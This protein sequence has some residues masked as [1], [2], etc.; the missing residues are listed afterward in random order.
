VRSS[1]AGALVLTMLSSLAAAPLGAEEPHPDITLFF[2]AASSDEELAKAALDEISGNWRDGYTAMFIDFARMMRP[3]SRARNATNEG[4]RWLGGESL[5]ADS[6]DNSGTGETP[7]GLSRNENAGASDPGSPIRRRLLQFLKK[8]TGRKYGDDLDGWRRWMWSLPYDPHPEYA[9]LKA[10]I[11]RNIDP[12]MTEFL[13]PDRPAAIRLDEIDWGGVRVNGVPPLD[14][15]STI[16]ADAADY[17]D[18]DDVVFGVEVGGEPRA[19]PKRI[20]GWHELVRDTVGETE[21]T[22]VYCTMCGSV[23]PYESRLGDET[24][25]FGTSGLLYR[26]NKLMFD[27]ET[28]TLWSSLSG[29]PVVGPRVGSGQRLKRMPVVATTWAEWKALHP[30]TTVLSTETGF[31]KDYAQG[32]AYEDYERTDRLWFEVPAIDKRLKNKDLVLTLEIDGRALAISRKF[33]SRN[34]VYHHTLAGEQLVFLTSLEGTTRAYSVGHTLIEGWGGGL[35]VLDRDDVSWRVDEQ[36]LESEDGRRLPR[37][38]TS[39]SYWFGWYAQY[40]DTELVK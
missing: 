15:P 5:T 13:Y 24:M 4:P 35:T 14:H 6:N 17:L 18:D 12:R 8:R 31:D 27:E 32:A 34:R 25:T 30:E 10:G 29:T 37:V 26:S 40:P 3:S 38:A 22:L 1:P 33:L 9:Y 20:L 7:L 16:A 11:Y 2:Q 36:A 19:Y 23:I 39:P 28:M 21:I